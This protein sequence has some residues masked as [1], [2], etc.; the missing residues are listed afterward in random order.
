MD[1]LIR[2]LGDLGFEQVLPPPAEEGEMFFKNPRLERRFGSQIFEVS[3]PEGRNLVLPPTY[4]LSVI[5]QYLRDL[6][7]NGGSSCV[8][9]RFY[10]SP[11]MKSGKSEQDHK[12]EHEVGVFILGEDSTLANAHLIYTLNQVLNN[13]GVKEFLTEI[14]CLGCKTCQKDYQNILQDHLQK[15]NFDLCNDCAANLEENVLAVWNCDNSSCQ[16]ILG[17]APQIVDFLDNSCHA[18]LIGVLEAID[19]LGIPYMLNPILFDHLTWQKILFRISV[20]GPRGE[21][22]V[23]GLGGN[24][25]VWAESLGENIQAPILGFLG[26]FE[27]LWQL[28]PEEQ[29]RSKR[30]VAVFILPVGEVASRKA[31]LLQR[32]LQQAGISAAESMLGN[33]G[34]K[35]QLKEAQKRRPEISLIIGQKEAIDGTVI[36]RDMRSG[37]QEL[38]AADRIIDEVKK[39]LG[40]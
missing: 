14:N 11:I 37:M 39:R 31:L 33:A 36:L 38:F 18:C 17:S 8:A 27:K 34:I 9:K 20:D 28:I 19:E 29:K 23:L 30:S 40:Q 15:V 25:T 6:K 7:A 3:A 24:Y 16:T 22:I 32:Q 5:K 26:S 1:N 21:K 4:F 35:S 10:I 13:L 12:L 2:S